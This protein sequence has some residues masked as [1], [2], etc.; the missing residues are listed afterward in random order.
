[1]AAKDRVVR[2]CILTAALSGAA[3]AQ[4]IRVDLDGAIHPLSAEIVGQAIEM[5]D[6]QNAQAVL[7]ILNTP[8]GLLSAT[9]EITQ[10]IVGSRTPVITYVYPP[11]GK[12][13]SA[14]FMIL[15]AGDVAA[16]APGANTGAAHPILLGG[17][18]MDEVMKQKIEQD[19][20]ASLRAIVD[21]RGR[22]AE[23]AQEAVLQSRAFTDQEAL[24]ANLIDLIAA[25]VPALLAELEQRSVLRFD[26]EQETLA[27]ADALVEPFPLTYRQRILL[28]LTDPNL[29]FILLALGVVGVYVEFTNPGLVFPGV[30]GG[31]LVIVGMMALSLLPINWAGAALIIF[32]IACLVAEAFTAANGILTVG[33]AVAMILGTVM[34]IDTDVPELSIGWGTAIAVTLPFVAITAFLLNLVVRSFGYKVA[35]G[36]EG[37]VGEIG[38]AKS[39]IG[40]S[41]QVFVHGELWNA[42]ADEPIPAGTSVKVEEVSG[43]RVRVAPVHANKESTL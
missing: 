3:S 35:T 28:P 38:K 29:A 23:L 11:G 30:F 1:M 18:E 13:A 5:A 21:K 40:E 15:Q 37:M 10:A 43:L 2:I 22:N 7:I 26:G 31:V 24:D 6:E 4:V 8:G 9:E 12:A 27:L 20:A 36:T 25:D 17:G 33:G 42:W 32:G 39:A 14:G 34:L 16:M 19:T 41:G